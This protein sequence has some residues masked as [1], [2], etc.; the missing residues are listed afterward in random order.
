LQG[1][2]FFGKK[3]FDR[4]LKC[5]DDEHR[6]AGMPNIGNALN[7]Q[8]LLKENYINQRFIGTDVILEN[9]DITEVND[10]KCF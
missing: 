8:G 5:D 10:E 9:A 6:K 7:A 1:Q 4:E 2:D 3:K